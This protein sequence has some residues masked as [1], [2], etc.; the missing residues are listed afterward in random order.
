MN[1]NKREF[2]QLGAPIFEQIKE[3]AAT[4]DQKSHLEPIP[5]LLQSVIDH[6]LQKHLIPENKKPNSCIVNF[7]DEPFLKPPHIDQPISTLL[8]SE[9]KM[10][11]GR[12]LISKNDGN[13][14][15]TLMLSLNEGAL[16]VMRGN[17]SDM[18]RYVMCPSPNKR[19][20]ISFFRVRMDTNLNNSS[21]MP[22]LTNAMIL[23]QSRP[24]RGALNGLE[25]MGM[26]SNPGLVIHTP[27]VMLSPMVVSP[28]V[29]SPGG[30][31]VFLPWTIGSRKPAKFL[32]PQA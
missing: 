2:T 29:I 21:P 4:E 7:F 14:K 26:V 20:S 19:V 11:F 25:A 15:G 5:A 16:L 30:T 18:A 13:Y 23:W 24:H 1:G 12:T 22:H 28:G 17:S 27:V 32:P 6:L 31:G 8:L 9:S 10:A 3:E